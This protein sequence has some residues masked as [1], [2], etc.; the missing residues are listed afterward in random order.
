MKR[1]TLSALGSLL[2]G[3]PLLG[4]SAQT[5]ILPDVVDGGGWQSTIVLTNVSPNPASATLSFNMGTTG[6]STQPWTPPFQEVSSTAGLV[7]SGGSSMF[8]HTLGTAAV[9]SQGWG[10]VNA[11]LGIVGYVIFTNRIPGLPNQDATAPA[12]AAANDV[13][14]PYDDS[15]GFATGIAIVNPMSTPQDISVG[16][17]TTTGGVATG[18]IPAVPPM[19]Y[20]AFDLA[21]Q[22]PVI[23][24]HV[25]LAE[26]YSATGTL[27]LIALRFNPTNSSTAAP[28][29]FQTG[30][31][32]IVSTPSATPGPTPD[33]GDPYGYARSVVAH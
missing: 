11:D 7:L 30:A 20:L 24:G 8:L 17:R 22:F 10:Q 3:L 27:S 12:V 15:T 19:G 6:G 14:V 18:I 31:P 2:L 5:L 26:F 9:L 4:Q 29:F 16:F 33:P 13:L 28:A 23:A 32:L 25:G 1:T 21:T